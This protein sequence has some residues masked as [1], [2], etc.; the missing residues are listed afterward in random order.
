MP[1]YTAQY[2][3]EPYPLVEQPTVA[4]LDASLGPLANAPPRT[5]PLNALTVCAGGADT[6]FMAGALVGWTQS[7]TRP[8]FDVVTGISGGATV[9]AFAYLGPKYDSHLQRLFTRLSTSD[10]IHVK[11]VRYLIRDRAIASPEPLERLLEA[12]ITDEFMADVR[13]AH[14]QGRRLF[15]G[16]TNFETKRQVVW[17]IGA[18]ASSGRPGTAVLIRKIMLASSTWAGIMPPV[19]ITVDECG[20]SCREYHIDGGA[21]AQAFVCFGPTP[22]WPNPGEPAP[23][24]L[25]GSN[26]YVLAGGKLFGTAQPAPERFAGRIMTGISCLT[27]SLARADMNRLYALCESSGMRFHLLAVPADDPDRRPNLLNLD[28]TQTQRM[29]ELGY[30]LTSTGPAWRRTPPGAEP[31]EEVVPRG[32]LPGCSYR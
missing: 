6:S 11:P 21:T 20:R 4:A 16:T 28:P 2:P 31:G 3:A 8:T 7:G 15:I 22:G 29:F 18:I 25:A 13:E 5:K 23:G 14:S 17:D 32:A 24:W 9:A 1:T 10:L 27:H 26:L 12:E 30:Q 19:E